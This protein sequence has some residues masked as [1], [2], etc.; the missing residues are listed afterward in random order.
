VIKVIADGQDGHTLEDLQG[1][2]LGWVRGQTIGFRGLTDE[3]HALRAVAATWQSVQAA[4]ARHYFGRQQRVVRLEELRVQAYNGAEWIVDEHGPV[5]RL[6]RAADVR[7]GDTAIEYLLPSY[8][9]EGALIAVAV[10][11]GRAFLTFVGGVGRPAAA[12][13]PASAQA[14]AEARA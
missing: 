14:R 6:V 8:A 1:A 12:L 9:S 2:R 4:L 3:A 5:A 13:V 11:A 10:V 7:S